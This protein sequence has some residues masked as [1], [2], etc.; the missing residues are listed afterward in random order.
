M[1]TLVSIFNISE[2]DAE[3]A[4]NEC[5]GNLERSIDYLLAKQ[6]AL[7]PPISSLSS[8]TTAPPPPSS[9]SSTAASSSTASSTASSSEVTNLEISQYSFDNGTSSCTSICLIVIEKLLQQLLL[10]NN[11]HNN[12]ILCDSLIEGISLHNDIN[13]NNNNSLSHLSVDEV[14]ILSKTLQKSLIYCVNNEPYQGLLNDSNSFQLLFNKLF[15]N[16]RDHYSINKHIA[17]VITKPPETICI[18][19]PP[20]C[21]NTMQLYHLFDSHS[22]PQEGHQGAYLISDSMTKIIE[23]VKKIWPAFIDNES[24]SY[25]MDMYNTFELH[26]FQLN[27]NSNNNDTMI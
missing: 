26:A 15:N 5:D 12:N 25:I 20:L 9:S 16:I 23:H 8:S 1:E 13:T 14:Y 7:P 27:D 22:R 10:G 19:I 11:I 4:L 2:R 6:S 21:N 3:I 24:D 17:C 18:I